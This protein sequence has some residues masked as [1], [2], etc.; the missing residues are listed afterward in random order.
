MSCIAVIDGRMSE[1]NK[2][3][4]TMWPEVMSIVEVDFGI[5]VFL[6]FD[7]VIV[8]LCLFIKF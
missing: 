5:V 2:N 4:N 1:M 8:C 6:C 3:P 7:V